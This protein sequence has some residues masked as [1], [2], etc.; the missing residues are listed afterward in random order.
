VDLL[1]DCEL[2][3]DFYHAMTRAVLLAAGDD[4]PVVAALEGGYTLHVI[5]DC[6]EA[7]ALALMNRDFEPQE[8]DDDG[9]GNVVESIGDDGGTTTDS[10]TNSHNLDPFIAQPELVA[11]LA[12]ASS[13]G[14][15]SC[16]N[17]ES[18]KSTTAHQLQKARNV[19]KDYYDYDASNCSSSTIQV[20]ASAIR[21]INHSIAAMQACERW[22]DVPFRTLSAAVPARSN[23]KTTASASSTF[24]PPTRQSARAAARKKKEADESAAALADA[25]QSLS[26][27][28]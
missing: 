27:Q 4:V 19:L 8:D 26:I 21:N 20:K 15:D 11:L 16:N 24:I 17:R 18:I 3:P 7:V 5:A 1:G 25:L 10:K 6:M 23:N 14:D 12:S 9:R 22:K 13:D 28:E 2:T